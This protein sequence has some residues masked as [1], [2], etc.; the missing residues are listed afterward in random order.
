MAETVSSGFKVRVSN[1]GTFAGVGNR[2][3]LAVYVLLRDEDEQFLTVEVSLPS[4]IVAPHVSGAH[5]SALFCRKFIDCFS[6]LIFPHLTV[7][8]MDYNE[9]I[10]YDVDAD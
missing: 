3:G 9:I 7:V 8:P 6:P 2:Q 1:N 5:T 10:D 4:V